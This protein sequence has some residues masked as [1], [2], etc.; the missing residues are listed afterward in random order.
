MGRIP[1]AALK[2]KDGKAEAGRAEAGPEALAV[3]QARV[4]GDKRRAVSGCV[5]RVERTRI[6]HTSHG[7]SESKRKF[8]EQL[9]D[10]WIE[11]EKQVWVR[12][13]EGLTFWGFFS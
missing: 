9:E 1:L 5:L 12:V 13:G 8:K 3:I 10:F 7:G 6:G 11:Q 4:A 2:G